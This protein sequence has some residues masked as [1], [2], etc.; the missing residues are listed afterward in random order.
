[1][2]PKN[3]KT[4]FGLKRS[5][6][7]IFLTFLKS[8]YRKSRQYYTRKKQSLQIANW[9]IFYCAK[10]NFSRKW[11]IQDYI[12]L[13]NSTISVTV[14]N[15][16]RNKE[17]LLLI[18]LKATK[19]FKWK[20]WCKKVLFIKPILERLLKKWFLQWQLTIL[21]GTRKNYY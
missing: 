14:D 1:M 10:R 19:L 12:I 5:N 9:N 8:A 18:N 16:V 20:T 15:I 7:V 2:S 3:S 17:G 4:I 13:L 21:S 6:S 11:Q